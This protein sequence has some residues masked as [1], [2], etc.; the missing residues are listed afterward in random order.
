MNIQAC[1][2]LT[3]RDTR[4]A[5]ILARRSFVS[6]S[7]VLAF[8]DLLWVQIWNSNQTI[9][10]IGGVNRSI[11]PHLYNFS[12]RASV[13]EIGFGLMVGTGDTA[14]AITDYKLETQILHGVGAG[15]LYHQGSQWIAP[16][17]IGARRHFYTSRE[18]DNQSG[19][20][21]TVKE[22]GIYTR[23]DTSYYLC[24]IRDII[25]AG[26]QAVAHNQT[27]TIQYEIYVEV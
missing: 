18:F 7:Y 26:G 5:R 2:T 14:V 20:T 22:C 21:I 4:T 27:L 23:A 11:G 1:V 25:P 8:L 13:G 19:A 15:Q 24:S 10:D 3:L 16:S 6:R 12:A 9:K 17:T